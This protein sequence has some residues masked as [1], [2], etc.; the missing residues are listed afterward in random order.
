MNKKVKIHAIKRKQLY[1]ILFTSLTVFFIALSTIFFF[2]WDDMSKVLMMVFFFISILG[3][4]VSFAFLV[5]AL[6]IKAKEFKLINWD[7]EI[8]F[9]FYH[10]YIMVNDEIVVEEK[11]AT[12]KTLILET[13]LAKKKLVA[14]NIKKVGLKVTLD[15]KII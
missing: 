5:A 14:K 15:N 2:L 12:S 1:L 4:V 7:I 10:H 9:G 13:H 8:Y 6:N 3:F 11:S